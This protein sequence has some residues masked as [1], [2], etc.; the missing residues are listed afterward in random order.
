MVHMLHLTVHHRQM[1]MQMQKLRDNWE[2]R[3]LQGGVAVTMLPDGARAAATQM[4]QKINSVFTF[5]VLKHTIYEQDTAASSFL[6]KADLSANFL[7]HGG[8]KQVK[9][10][11]TA[12]KTGED[13]NITG[14]CDFKQ[15]VLGLSDVEVTLKSF[16]LAPAEDTTALV[17][18]PTKAQAT[19][20]KALP[21]LKPYPAHTIT[22]LFIVTMA[23][24]RPC[25]TRI[26]GMLL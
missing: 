24:C 3:L 6:V 17:Q 23:V 10:Q 13:L 4:Q 7:L 14:S 11:V 20:T 16:K 15:H 2:V 19:V 25:T 8:H 22:T 18:S 1:Q 21:H 9:M 26:G 12:A 5:P